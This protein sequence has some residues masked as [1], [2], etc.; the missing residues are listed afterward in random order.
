ME[1]ANAVVKFVKGQSGHSE[2]K[3]YP[4]SLV[5][6]VEPPAEQFEDNLISAYLASALSSGIMYPIDT[7]KTRQQTGRQTTLLQL[8]V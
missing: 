6:K 3:L 8:I 1:T 7:Y 4:Y 2:V 5:A